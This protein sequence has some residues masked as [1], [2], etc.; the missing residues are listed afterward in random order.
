MPLNPDVEA[1]LELV[2]LGRAVGK[3]Q[4]MHELTVEQARAEF[5]LSAAILDPEPPRNI[6]VSSLQVPT[7]TGDSIAARLY[8]APQCQADNCPVILYFHGGG[9]VVGSL[10]SHDVVCRRLSLATGYAVM[11]PAYRLAPEHRLPAAFNDALDSAGWLAMNAAAL[12]LDPSNIVVAGD[13]AG[14]TLATQVAIAS[15]PG[16]WA[17]RAQLLFYPVAD[18]RGAYP[19]LER[20]GEGYLLESGTMKWFYQHYLVS[21]VD[22]ADPRVSPLLTPGLPAQVPTYISVAQFDPLHDEGLA[23]ATFLSSL[24]TPVTLRV[25]EGLTHDFLRMSGVS[26]TVEAIYQATAQWLKTIAY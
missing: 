18:A 5:E 13:S 7:R 17:P 10:D 25:E 20:Y 9:Y 14:A 23:Y 12:G 3:S 11:A 19:S 15:R 24:G 1:F 26:D 22:Q 6:E 16:A 4:P 8:R 21:E 2:E